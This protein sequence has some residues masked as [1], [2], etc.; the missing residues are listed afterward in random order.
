MFEAFDFANFWDDDP[1]ALAEYVSEPPSDA[2][3]ASIEQELGYILPLAHEAAQRRYA[4]KHLLSHRHTHQLVGQSC[5]NHGDF[6]Y[7]T[8]KAVFL[9]RKFGQPVHD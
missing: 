6:R 8:G 7:W 1:Y 5:G 3:I 4:E 9:M 2:L